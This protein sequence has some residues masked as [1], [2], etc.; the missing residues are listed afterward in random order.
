MWCWRSCGDCDKGIKNVGGGDIENV[1]DY[2]ITHDA[3]DSIGDFSR[4]DYNLNGCVT[5]TI[6]FI[7]LTAI[8]EVLLQATTIRSIGLLTNEQ[9]NFLLAYFKNVQEMTKLGI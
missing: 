6:R 7:V 1:D 2:D 5:N 3:G 8:V 9:S 4:G